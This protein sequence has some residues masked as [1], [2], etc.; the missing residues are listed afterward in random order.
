MGEGISVI[1][2]L[3]G[4]NKLPPLL[5]RAVK[6]LQ[7]AGKKFLTLIVADLAGVAFGRV[8]G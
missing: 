6:N 1:V 3:W 4:G 8:K 2:A 7:P 5:S